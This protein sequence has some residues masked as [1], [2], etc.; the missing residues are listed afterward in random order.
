MGNIDKGVITYVNVT[1]ARVVPSGPQTVSY[2]LIIP[3]K[4]RGSLSVGDAVV[5][6]VFDDNTGIILYR[7]DGEELNAAGTA[8]IYGESTD[9][10]PTTYLGKPMKKGSLFL[11][12]DTGNIYYYTGSEW[13][14]F[15]WNS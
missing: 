4:L 12:L 8:E 10:K 6:S 15:G 11:E 13:K 3:S 2:D 1:V 7:A 9:T 5:F 14:A